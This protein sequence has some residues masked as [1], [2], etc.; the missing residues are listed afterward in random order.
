MSAIARRQDAYAGGTIDRD[1]S[2]GSGME[3]W[4]PRKRCEEYYGEHDAGAC[5]VQTASGGGLRGWKG[6]MRV[7]G[8]YAGR[9]K[10]DEMGGVGE[11]Y[12][13]GVVEGVGSARCGG[14]GLSGGP[15]VHL[16]LARKMC[17]RD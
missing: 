9:G 3:T 4:R 13:T 5:A 8:R 10:G 17:E 15:H 2:I 11:G 12:W 16:R 7:G 14:G 6:D 1:W